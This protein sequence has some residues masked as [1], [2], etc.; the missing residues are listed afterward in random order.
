MLWDGVYMLGGTFPQK[1]C[2]DVASAPE[3]R[4]TPTKNEIFFQNM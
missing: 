3:K 1:I 4:K 2:P